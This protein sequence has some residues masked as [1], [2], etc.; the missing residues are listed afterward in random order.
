M[1]RVCLTLVQPQTTPQC[2]L[3]L[4]SHHQRVNGV[5]IDAFNESAISCSN[6]HSMMIWDL[7]TLEHK[8]TLGA[9]DEQLAANPLS[10]AFQQPNIVAGYTDAKIRVW[11]RTTGNYVKQLSGHAKEITSVAFC[12]DRIISGSND[13]TIKI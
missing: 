3:S 9:S 10:V 7:K 5:A 6:D 4:E 12:K 13:C 11:D 1:E 8:R 2:S